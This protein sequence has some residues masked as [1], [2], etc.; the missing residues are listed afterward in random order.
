MKSQSFVSFDFVT[1]IS[2]LKSNYI[3]RDILNM[4]DSVETTYW[5]FHE[6]QYFILLLFRPFCRLW[7]HIILIWNPSVVFLSLNDVQKYFIYH[8]YIRIAFLSSFKLEIDFDL[9]SLCCVWTLNRW[10][11]SYY[12]NMKSYAKSCY[13]DLISLSFILLHDILLFFSLKSY[14]FNMNSSHLRPSIQLLF[15]RVSILGRP[16]EIL[17]W[18]EK[19]N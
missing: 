5:I 19:K 6:L 2:S 18:C 15:S 9:E 10:L 1:L 13:F 17:D 11:K 7:N 4:F 16:R 3:E 14:Y 8:L 12:F